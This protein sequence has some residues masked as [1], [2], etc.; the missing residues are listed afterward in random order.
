MRFFSRYSDLILK[1][2]LY[3]IVMSFFG[4]M[5]FTATSGNAFLFLLGQIAIL[6]FWAF[7]LFHQGMQKGQKMCEK[8]P[9][10]S[11]FGGFLPA[12]IAFLP[13]ILLSVWSY[14]SKPYA[15]DGAGQNLVPFLLN[16]TLLQGM[17]VG[18]AQKIFPTT[19]SGASS[20]VEVQNAAAL[21]RQTLLYLFT[22]LPGILLCGVGYLFGHLNFSGLK[23]KKSG[24]K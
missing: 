18:L 9:G 1:T 8:E 5:M 16:K 6:L 10:S 23:K 22:S 17:Y 3:Q 11:P 2:F 15:P 13:A 4:L 14:L 21:N 7:I 19:V 20:A 12:L 24:S